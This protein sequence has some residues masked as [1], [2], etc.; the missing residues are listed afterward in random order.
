MKVGKNSVVALG[1]LS[2][3]VGAH[4]QSSVTMYGVI[5]VGIAYVHNVAGAN[6][7]NES[8]LFKMN[9]GTR[10]GDR[11]GIKG[12]EDL[13]G[14]TS[15]IFQLENGF[16]VGTGALG[17]GGRE[18]GRQAFVGLSGTSWGTVTLGRQ[19]DPLVD[20]VEGLTADVLT[21]AFGTPGDVDNYDNSMRVSNAVKYVSPRFGGFLVEG[22]YGFGGEA[23]A[24][25]AGQSWGAALNYAN[26][27]V[28]LAGGYFHASGGNTLT[29]A[30]VRTWT[31]SA[32]SPFN[33]SINTGFATAASLQ[34][35]RVGGSYVLGQATFGAAYSNTQYASDGAS[36]FHSSA[37]FNNGSTYLIYKF[38]PAITGGVGYNYTSLTGPTSAHYHQGNLLADYALSNRTDVY[39]VL[40]YQRASGRTLN[41][42]GES[43]EATAV[44]GDFATS[45]GTN[46]QALAVVGLRHKF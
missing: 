43:V 39:A 4:A 2:A 15:A 12:S 26:G 20:Q 32:D 3:V 38:T 18:F 6:G 30:G 45:S 35:I 40:G 1:C 5:D 21:G 25:G 13:G 19:Y 34:I 46:S 28:T 36:L 44:I 10:Q 16:N 22:L 11:W 8:T 27:P 42:A 33:T 37:K 31:S 23:G 7:V 29:A 17:Q 41:A 24:T 14:G 9:S